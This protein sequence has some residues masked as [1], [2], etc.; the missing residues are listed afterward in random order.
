MHSIVK[1]VSVLEDWS[2]TANY[3]LPTM[4][5][6][7]TSWGGYG[8][9]NVCPFVMVKDQ[10]DSHGE[11]IS[12]TLARGLRILAAFAESSQWLNNSELSE[13]TGLPPATV[14]RLC[15][16][17]SQLNILHHSDELRRF[18]L[19]AGVVKLSPIQAP[20]EDLLSRTYHLLQDI[21]DTHRVHVSLAVAD[22]TDALHLQV[23]HSEATLFTLRLE[24]GSRIPL[25]GT[26]TG[27]AILA[28][29]TQ[30]RRDALMPAL[31]AR[32]AKNWNAISTAID[33]AL[34]E[35]DEKGYTTSIGSWHTDI[36]GVAVP[37][38][39]S[40]GESYSIA[41]GAPSRHLSSKKIKDIGEEIARL[42]AT[43]SAG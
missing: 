26:A 11:A 25:A 12:S 37:I 33:A 18:R 31:E 42:A 30:A 4:A 7:L 38:V 5:H 43:L 39:S 35:I 3:R 27:H 2:R 41:C 29:M 17:L 1:R 36:N 21:A 10:A 34:Q 40:D 28:G 19:A 32:H 8:N 20:R 15:S 22:G 13:R 24:V 14:S 16:S 23:C 6:G 9:G